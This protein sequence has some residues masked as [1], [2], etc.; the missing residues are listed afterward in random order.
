M[1]RAHGS[2]RLW[3]TARLD[4]S[5]FLTA[6][7]QRTGTITGEDTGPHPHNPSRPLRSQRRI[8]LSSR[9][10]ITFTDAQLQR[11]PTARLRRT[12]TA[13]SRSTWEER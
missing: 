12:A 2:I 10:C 8:K 3:P 4:F 6:R 7:R 11:T 1:I 13:L 5:T 9:S